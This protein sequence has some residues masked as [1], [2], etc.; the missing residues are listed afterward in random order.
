MTNAT[1]SMDITLGVGAKCYGRD[2]PGAVFCVV[3]WPALIRATEG[4]FVLNKRTCIVF[5]EGHAGAREA[6]EYAASVL[7]PAT[8]YDFPVHSL[9]VLT[10][11]ANAV[12][13]QEEDRG[14][15]SEGYRLRAGPDAVSILGNTA[16][17]LFYGV[18]SLRQLLPPAIFDA[19]PSTEQN[20]TVPGVEIEDYPRFAWRGMLLDV[21]RHF[22]PVEFL[23]K[24][25]DAIALHKMNRLHLHLTDDQGW[26]IEI[27]R[28][29]RLTEVGAWRA[30]TQINHWDD[31]PLRFDGKPHGGYY[32]QGE[33]RELV[34][35]AAARHVTLVPE[36]EMP[37]HAQAAIAAYPELGAVET[38]LPVRTAWGANQSIYN[39]EESTLSFLQN[40]LTEVM[41]LFPGTFIHVGGDEAAKDHWKNS[42]AVQARMAA[43]GVADEDHL[44]RYFIERMNDFLAGKGRRLVGWDEILEGDLGPGPTV[45]AW[46]GIDKGIQAARS[47]KDVVMAP[48]EF[49]YF[50]YYQGPK[51]TEPL[52]IG[53]DLPLHKAY[54]FD[55]IP[56]E[57]TESERKHI[58]GAQGQVWTEFIPTTGH[59]E[60]MAF[61]RACALAE[62]VWT[63]QENRA[64]P[65]FLERLRVHLGRL[66]RI[67][68]RYRALDE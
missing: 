45:M 56:P 5:Q 60:Y 16:T 21:A 63:P 29:P 47:R 61:P 25:I 7:R 66:E 64:Y 37:G 54:A 27:K 23:K 18:Q 13:F 58:L 65:D 49:T 10:D 38:P 2:L 19:T 20:W 41:D 34:A 14:L 57:L 26:R 17:G 9:T 62:V 4:G 68:L 42:P 36:I 55:P 12:R 52:A 6:A 39:V 33:I 40:V 30:E 22:M 32:T 3:P 28:Y 1:S 53:G 67:G 11:Y 48:T 50:D 35:Y 59:A 31:P 15:A 43:L 8:G 24:F 46:R 44:Q 51:E